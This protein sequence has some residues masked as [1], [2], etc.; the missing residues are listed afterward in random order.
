[1]LQFSVTI[2]EQSYIYNIFCVL[3]CRSEK[4]LYGLMPRRQTIPSLICLPRQGLV[5]IMRS[6]TLTQAGLVIYISEPGHL[7]VFLESNIL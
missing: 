7:K 1:M 6:E 3:D 4:E 2:H 5:N